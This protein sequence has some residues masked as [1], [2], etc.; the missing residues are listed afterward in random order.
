MVRMGFTLL[1]AALLLPTA[2]PA[3]AP[4]RSGQQTLTLPLE[5]K[6]TSP[7]GFLH[8]E[9]EDARTA[10][11]EDQLERARDGEFFITEEASPHFGYSDAAVWL[12][13]PVKAPDAAGRWLLEIQ[14]PLLSR[15]Q[16]QVH[17]EDGRVTHHQ[18]GRNVAFDRWPVEHR[19]VTIPLELEAGEEAELVFR[20]T[21]TSSLQTPLVVW[22]E[23][24]FADSNQQ[25]NLW[26]GMFFGIILALLLYNLLLYFGLK[27]INYLFY[28]AYVGLYLLSE[29]I[30]RGFA[31]Q[32]LWP[33]MTGWSTYSIATI[34]GT[35]FIAA[36]AFSRSFLQLSQRMPKSNYFVL[37]LMASFTLAV[38]WAFVDPPSGTQLVA[39]LSGLNTLG[40]F[41]VAYLSLRTGFIQARY[42]LLAWTVFLIGTAAY[43]LRAM[44]V[45]PNVFLTEYGVQI[46][47]VVQMLML[48]FA[49]AHRMRIVQWEKESV[50]REAKTTLEQR[51]KERTVELDKALGELS[52]SNERLEYRT[53]LFETLV[54]TNQIA[55]GIRD[56]ETL[57]SRT[58]PLLDRALPGIGF[59]VI[60][61]SPGAPTAI[62]QVFFHNI[63][64]SLRERILKLLRGRKIES[65][66]PVKVSSLGDNRHGLIITMHNRLHEVEGLFLLVKTGS[67][68][69]AEEREAATLFADQLGASMEAV[70]LQR[71]LEA[72]T[73]TDDNTGLYNRAQLD[74][75]LHRE[76]KHKKTYSP[77]DYAAF[78][79]QIRDLEEVGQKYG[80]DAADQLIAAA[81]DQVVSCARPGDV[82]GHWRHDKLAIICPGT[83]TKEREALLEKL[84]QTVEGSSATLQTRDGESVEHSIRVHIGSADSEETEAESVVSL[85]EDRMRKEPS[86]E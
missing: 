82:V 34:I 27:D 63:E 4:D 56:P 11:F 51:V 38:L 53:R 54:E 83:R 30:L 39:V 74:K 43:G 67:G 62:T 72:N 86:A 24:G 45:V 64:E 15:V 21:S 57:L 29:M 26:F 75:L 20:I 9:L 73:E 18:G 10:S 25:S 46:G 35:A 14:H 6:R 52:S 58:V 50:E 48:S 17:H 42:F 40:L 47:A 2:A 85:A 60:A 55:P 61:R 77:L 81:A 32:Y 59:A 79:V 66:L 84:K 5:E 7:V 12:Y 22:T 3:Q 33:N 19:N 71:R 69:F 65:E 76:I 37:G 78:V 31:F 13:L 70:L 49:L 68:F 36:A 41:V 28:V 44:G 1:L 23:A 8:Y 80:H 16:V